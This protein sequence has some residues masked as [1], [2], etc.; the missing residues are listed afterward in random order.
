M[1]VKQSSGLFFAS[2]I[3]WDTHSDGQGTTD[4]F[5]EDPYVVTK[6]KKSLTNE[7]MYLHLSFCQVK[8]S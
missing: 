2:Y 6:K 3:S 7:P 8:K 1:N 4:W 5:V